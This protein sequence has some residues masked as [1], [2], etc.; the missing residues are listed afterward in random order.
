MIFL[1]RTPNCGKNHTVRASKRLGIYP[2]NDKFTTFTSQVTMSEESNKIICPNCQTPVDVSDVLHAQVEAE[3][4]AKYNTKWKEEVSKLQEEKRKMDE[5]AA[6][7]MKQREDF[8][9]TLQQKL[10]EQLG[11]QVKQK[12]QEIRMQLAQEN[13][14]SA[15]AMRRQLDEKQAQLKDYY[16]TKTALE[17]LRR[18]KEVLEERLRADFSDKLRLE[19]E[20]IRQEAQKQ[21]EQKARMQ[22][23]EREHIINQ[24]KEQLQEAQ[25]KAEQG[26][27]QI[28]GE[29]QELAIEDYLKTT[30][31]LDTID[32]I[33]KGARGGDCMQI[34]NTHTRANCGIIYYESKRTKDFQPQW[35]EKFKEDI[36]NQNAQFGVLVTEVMPKGMTRFG[37]RDGI[38]ICTFEEFKGL[39]MVLRESVILLNN[40]SLS[41]ENKGEKMHML[42]DFLTGNEFRQQVEAIVEGFTYM[43]RDLDSEKRAMEAIW[44]K[45]EKQIQ[46]VLLNTT[47]MY[48]SI[49]GIAGNAISEIRLLELSASEDTS[50]LPE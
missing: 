7:L 4:K 44:K 19:S 18:D 12:E 35:I 34:V 42:Y 41:Q 38:W 22:L 9:A 2:T 23:D 29:V 17:D 31:P 36:R 16:N 8:E 43:K 11:L 14:E 13:E 25:R 46:K 39:S 20:R 50:E 15:A 47:H 40:V 21:S 3:Y 24:L 27:M 49:K 10:K 32:E 37:L 48:A 1:F 33:R 26:S 6:T 45:R 30:F 28:Q 5:Q